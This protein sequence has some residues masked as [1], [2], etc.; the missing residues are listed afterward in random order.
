MT[1]TSK[2]PRVSIIV[3]VYNHTDFLAKCLESLSA[4]S[5]PTSEFEVL[6]VDNG[7][8]DSPKSL[9]EKY[10]FARFAIEE[11]PGSFAA[12]N[13]GLSMASAPVLAFTD[14]DCLPDPHWLECALDAIETDSSIGVVAG[15]IDVVARDP[16]NPTTI[17]L[18]DMVYRFD[19]RRR[20]ALSNGVVTANMVTRQDVFD[21]VGP[22]NDSLMSGADAEWSQRAAAAGYNVQYAD[23]VVVV[24][25]ARTSLEEVLRQARRRAGGR[26][27]MR[28]TG[29]RSGMIAKLLSAVKRILPRGAGLVEAR[30]KLRRRGYGWL[31]WLRVVGLLQVI[32]YTSTFELVRRLL[33][34]NPERR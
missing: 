19:Q 30:H 10:A 32:H 26:L 8:D 20:V 1:L 29:N 21:V 12:R 22:F 34:G 15:R 14:A 5:L 23:D 3:P 9:V 31:S 7:S 24:H 6:V 13:K 17:E 11:R 25:P 18:Y 28:A 16:D 27:D 33:G 4:Q 2:T